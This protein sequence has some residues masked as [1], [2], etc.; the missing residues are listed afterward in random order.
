MKPRLAVVLVTVALLAS[1]VVQPASRQA[2]PVPESY[3]AGAVGW[4]MSYPQCSRTSPPGGAFGVV[5]LNHG[6]PFTVDPCLGRLWGWAA[7]LEAPSLYVNAAFSPTYRRHLTPECTSRVPGALLDSVQR[8]AWAAGC[9]EA[10]FDVRVA[11]GRPAA[12]WLDVETAN[13]WSHTRP[14]LNRLAIQALATELRR[15]TGRPVGVYSY[16]KAWLRITGDG[17][18]APSGVLAS[19]E[20]PILPVTAT[21]A[22]GLCAE[23]GFSN[24]RVLLVQFLGKDAE[25]A[26]DGDVAC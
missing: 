10:V 20:A 4:D 24:L 3:P 7:D 16:F 12:W 17:Q 13:S 9:Q 2:A 8:L 22:N 11:P 26:F 6:R 14:T 1:L 23:S 5:G 21:T 15:Q 25:G 18:W 19:W